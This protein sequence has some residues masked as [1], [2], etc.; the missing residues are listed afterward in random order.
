MRRGFARKN[1]PDFAKLSKLMPGEAD[2]FPQYADCG[3][4]LTTTAD[5]PIAEDAAL[6]K[7]LGKLPFAF[8]VVDL[9]RST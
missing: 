8:S 5:Q 7:K 9:D 1:E 3:Y 6:M 4:F 2:C